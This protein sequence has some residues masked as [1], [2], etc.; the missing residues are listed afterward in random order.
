[1]VRDIII[2]VF[3][4]A[5]IFQFSENFGISDGITVKTFIPTYC[6]DIGFNTGVF[7]ISV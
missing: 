7:G 5:E 3:R 1:M 2:L 4:Y 6:T